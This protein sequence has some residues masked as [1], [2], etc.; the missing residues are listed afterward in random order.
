DKCH[1]QTARFRAQYVLENSRVEVVL[2]RAIVAHGV[3]GVPKRFRIAASGG[4][5]SRLLD[6]V[7]AAVGETQH[8]FAEM[9]CE[10]IFS[11]QQLQARSLDRQWRVEDHQTFPHEDRSCHFSLYWGDEAYSPGMQVKSGGV[12]PERPLANLYSSTAT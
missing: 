1:K 4:C 2:E 8:E 10:F 5:G 12:P 3:L 7:V 11:G 6:L 9:L